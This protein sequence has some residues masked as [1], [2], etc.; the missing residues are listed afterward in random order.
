MNAQLCADLTEGRF[1]SAW[2]GELDARERSL[3]SFS[4]GQ[5]PLLYYRAAAGTCET[6]ETDTVPLGCL[7]DLEVVLRDA[8]RMEPGDIFVALSD[9]VIDAESVRGERFGTGARDRPRHDQVQGL[10][11]G[12]GDGTAAGADRLHGGASPDDD[13]TVVL[14]KCG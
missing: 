4:C 8:I 9:G 1:I 14:I 12:A 2:V 7:D 5:G 10:G 6:L 3:K 13:R 11:R